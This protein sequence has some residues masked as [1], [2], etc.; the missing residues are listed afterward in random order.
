MVDEKAGI[1]GIAAPEE[2]VAPAQKD[3]LGLAQKKGGDG[4]RKFMQQTES[5]REARR[6]D[7]RPF[8]GDDHDDT[9]RQSDG[10]TRTLVRTRMMLSYP[11][12]LKPLR[13]FE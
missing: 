4:R 9:R 10:Q 12:R 7:R 5:V 1:A 6:R 8:V 13:T 11:R 2:H 3:R